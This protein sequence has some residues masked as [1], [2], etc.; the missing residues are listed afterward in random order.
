MGSV[1]DGLQSLFRLTSGEIHRVQVDISAMADEIV[2]KLRASSPRRKVEVDIAPNL[3][4]SADA[5]LAR[6]MLGN[7]IDNAWKFTGPKRKPAIGVGCELVDG[8]ARHFVTGWASTR[9]TRTLPAPS[10]AWYGQTELPGAGFP[11]TAR[12]IV[13]R[14]RR[15]CRAKARSGREPPSTSCAWTARRCI[16]WRADRPRVFI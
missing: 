13:N 11:A 16:G 1:F 12:R 15:W 14:P 7:L 2:G 3:S 10:S 9:C 4:V 8:E 6:I 5:R